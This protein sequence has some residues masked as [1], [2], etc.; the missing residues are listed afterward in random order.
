LVKIPESSTGV[1]ISILS[2]A[3]IFILQSWLCALPFLA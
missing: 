3:S 1:C 2:L